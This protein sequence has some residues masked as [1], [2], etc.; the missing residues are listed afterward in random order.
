MFKRVLMTLLLVAVIMCVAAQPSMA[1]VTWKLSHHKPAD[2]D[3]GKDMQKLADDIEKATE[4]RVKVKVFPAGQLGNSEMAIERTSIGAIDI[5]LGY[6]NSELSNALDIYALPGLATDYNQIAKVY[7]RGTPFAK[8]LDKLFAEQDLHVLAAY[9]MPFCG[10]WFSKMPKEDPKNPNIKHSE[11][12]RVPGINCFRFPGESFGYNITAL[13]F[14]EVFTA[15]QTGVID[16]VY[17]P[18]AESAYVSL[19][20]VVKVY[21]PVDLQPDTFF[22]LVNQKAFEKLSEKDREA[23]SAVGLKLEKDGFA[24]GP[25]KAAMWDKRITDYGINMLTL[26]PAEKEAF[27]KKAIDYSW[28][29]LKESIGPTYDDGIAAWKKS[30]Q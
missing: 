26:S 22:V 15:L 2:S 25:K 12:I 1:A 3:I 29:K 30:L 20:D 16:G 10:L 13:P 14:T 18:S 5:M 4:G 19:R 9:T 28:P 21:V 6:P 23:V 17:G 11:K 27:K 7:G 24:N 8:H